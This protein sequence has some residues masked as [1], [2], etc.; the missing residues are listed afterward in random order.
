[1]S[2]RL[3]DQKPGAGTLFFSRGVSSHLWLE[4]A[5]GFP[6]LFEFR[7]IPVERNFCA[8]DCKVTPA[9]CAC[10]E[11]NT[12]GCIPSNDGLDAGSGSGFPHK[13]TF[14]R[15]QSLKV[16]KFARSPACV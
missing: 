13:C 9:G 2:A 7:A 10:Q 4:T 16:S 3:T 8:W 15:F 12:T 11:G 6:S 5:A 1:M 14:Q